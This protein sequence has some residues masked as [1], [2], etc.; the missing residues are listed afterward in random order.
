MEQ[1][2]RTFARALA[3]HADHATVVTLSGELGAG[4]TTFARGVLRHFGVEE[5]VTSPTFVIMKIYT[6]RTG[7][8]KRIVHM[9]SYRLK[10]K[11]HLAILGW[12]E[13]LADPKTLILMEWPE[14]V[15]GAAPAD[16]TRLR[17]HWVSAESREIEVCG[18]TMV[19]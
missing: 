5:S 12:H 19:A 4:K 2:A 3:P 10:G 13:M 16:A 18:D 7:P 11:H 9:D 15:E 14:M 8:F 1:A 17:F 6:P